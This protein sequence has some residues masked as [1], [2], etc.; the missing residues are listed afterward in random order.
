M[1]K[2]YFDSDITL[3]I[4]D[5]QVLSGYD[6][7]DAHFTQVGTTIRGK[8]RFPLLEVMRVDNKL[9]VHFDEDIYDN[10]GSYYP[11]TV[12]AIFTL[13]EG[14]IQRWEEVAYTKYFCQAGAAN[15]VYSNK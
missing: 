4:N 1:T 7:F 9:I 11:T 2:K 8:I 14:K 3:I 6:Q 15:V 12:I 13:H 10:Y 5:K